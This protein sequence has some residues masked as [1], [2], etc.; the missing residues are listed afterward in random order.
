MQRSLLPVLAI[1]LLGT[2]GCI[3]AVVGAAGAGAG[4]GYT[5]AQK[6]NTGVKQDGTAQPAKG[7][8]RAKTVKLQPAP[9]QFVDC[10]LRDGAKLAMSAADC[11]AKGGAAS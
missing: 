2:S 8:A 5:Q 4:L 11:K 6:T 7:T 10:T 3:A 1:V 9:G